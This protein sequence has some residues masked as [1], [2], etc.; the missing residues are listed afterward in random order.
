MASGDLANN[1]IIIGAGSK[2]I[3]KSE[4]LLSD[5]ALK[6][7]IPSLDGYATESWVGTQNFITMPEDL[8]ED[9]IVI[10]A[11]T[12]S[13]T[14]KRLKTING[15]SLLV[16]DIYN[17]TNYNVSRM[18]PWYAL[19]GSGNITGLYNYLFDGVGQL[20]PIKYNN[21]AYTN[22]PVDGESFVGT[23]QPYKYTAANNWSVR[24]FLTSENTGKTYTGVFNMGQSALINWIEIG[25]DITSSEIVSALGFTPISSNEIPVALPNPYALSIT[26]NGTNNSYTGSSVVNINLDSIF[27]KKLKTVTTPG[28]P[29]IF[30]GTG[31]SG[32]TYE[33]D[34]LFVSADEPDAIIVIPS[35]TSISF[36]NTIYTEMQD[37]GTLTGGTYKCYCITYINSS[38]VLVNGAIYGNS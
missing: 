9:R 6:S 34:T 38:I 24:A 26:A 14:S 31:A 8:A 16:D 7:D 2:S 30:V 5:L 27:S 3:K 19:T 13:V 20:I 33:V 17:V 21:S 25:K 28:Q 12:N 4:Q 35:S 32:A 10:G 15:V 36:D 29:G 22:L 23:L 11:G 1:Y 37:L 18:F